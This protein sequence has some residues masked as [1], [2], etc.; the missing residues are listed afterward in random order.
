MRCPVP[1]ALLALLGWGAVDAAT[2]RIGSWVRAVGLA[3]RAEHDR[4][5]APDT[6]LPY[7][8]PPAYKGA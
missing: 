7:E 5:V 4:P 8:E 1:Y 6:L 2:R 3:A